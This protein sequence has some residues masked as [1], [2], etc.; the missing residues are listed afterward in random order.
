MNDA[1]SRLQTGIRTRVKRNRLR[2]SIK[3][4]IRRTRRR[5]DRRPVAHF[6]HIGKT[7][8][9]ALR[10]PLTKVGN[11]TAFRMILHN[12]DW[13]LD[14]VPVGEKFFF[15]VRDPADR[16]VSA[17]VARQ[18]FDQPRFFVPWSEGERR[19]YEQFGSPDELA[20]SLSAGGERQTAAENAMRNIHHV[21]ASYWDW[22]IDP[23][24]FLSRSDDL[25]WIG[26]QEALDLVGL[27]RVLGVKELKMP[28]DPVTANRTTSSKPELSSLALENLQQWYSRDYEFLDLCN[29]LCPVAGHGIPTEMRKGTKQ[30]SP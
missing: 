3:K 15:C 20:T 26:R 30:Q 1:I 9:T 7:A 17:F 5:F 18:R 21:N 29:Q 24:Y 25:L 22:F 23:S 19:A 6:L 2:K 16:F 12:H 4:K 13:H 8:G 10:L 27:A 14:S 28:D 11:K